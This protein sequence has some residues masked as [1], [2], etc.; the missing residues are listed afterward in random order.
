MYNNKTWRNVLSISKICRFCSAKSIDATIN[1]KRSIQCGSV[2]LVTHCYVRN[3]SD[4][5]LPQIWKILVK[6]PTRRFDS[7]FYFI[8]S[9]LQVSH[10]LWVWTVIW[11][12]CDPR[13]WSDVCDAWGH[14]ELTAKRRQLPRIK[15][16][17][18]PD[19]NKNN[20]LSSSLLVYHTPYLVKTLVFAISREAGYSLFLS[21][22]IRT[23]WNREILTNT[24]VLNSYHKRW[25]W[26]LMYGW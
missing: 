3:C 2:K 25:P 24:F 5:C 13:W 15:D 19:L 21:Y 11:V 26:Y 23:Y 10:A 20:Y 1:G 16:A 6:G 17:S 7:Q 12:S 8:R 14:A 9:I 22:T 4:E 18:L